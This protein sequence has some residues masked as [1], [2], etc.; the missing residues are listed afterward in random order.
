MTAAFDARSGTT[1]PLPGSADRREVDDRSAAVLRHVRAASR[2]HCI[3]AEA[4]IAMTLWKSARSSSRNRR[5]I[6]PDTPALL[7]MTCKPPKCSTA[8][9]TRPLTWSMSE[10]SASTKQGVVADLGGQRR[11]VSR[12]MSPIS[13]CAPSAAKRR[14]SPSPEPGRAAGDDRD[15]ALPVRQSSGADT[16]RRI[17]LGEKSRKQLV[18]GRRA[19]RSAGSDRRCSITAERPPGICSAISA[20]QPGG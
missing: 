17:R 13:T 4:L 18:D 3:T 11:H 6:V 9:A 19:A 8:V 10:T 15:L 16:F 2:V 7:T 20:A 12:S 5:C 14:T 1:P